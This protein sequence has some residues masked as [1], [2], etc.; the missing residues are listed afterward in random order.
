MIAERPRFEATGPGPET[1]GSNSATVLIPGAAPGD[2]SMTPRSKDRPGGPGW[3]R[4]SA[5][6]DCYG[7][8]AGD[9]VPVLM[10]GQR[11]LEVLLGQ[12]LARFM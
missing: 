5:A 4:G 1:V 8:I 11:G 9:G 6:A 7:V 10:A 2:H 3:A 12:L